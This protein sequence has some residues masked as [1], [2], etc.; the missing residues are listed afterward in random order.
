MVGQICSEIYIVG[1]A[2]AADE[3]AREVGRADLS[4]KIRW[5]EFHPQRKNFGP[6]RAQARAKALVWLARRKKRAG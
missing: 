4:Q 3:F 6:E 5:G 1:G 2:R